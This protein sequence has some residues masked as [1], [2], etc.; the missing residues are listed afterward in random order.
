MICTFGDLT[1]VTWWRDLSLPTRSVVG[2]DGRL[3]P[4]PFGTPGWESVDADGRTPPT[5]RS[6]A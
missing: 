3:G 1:D 4:A 2:K 5:P 6:R